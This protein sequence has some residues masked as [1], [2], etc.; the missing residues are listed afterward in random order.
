MEYV[1]TCSKG[2]PLHKVQVEKNRA[3]RDMEMEPIRSTYRTRR[4]NNPRLSDSSDSESRINPRTKSRIPLN[5]AHSI[6]RKYISKNQ[7]D[8]Q[9]R[10]AVV[11][12]FNDCIKNPHSMC[13]SDNGSVEKVSGQQNRHRSQSTDGRYHTDHNRKKPAQ[14]LFVRSPRKSQKQGPVLEVFEEALEDTNLAAIKEGIREIQDTKIPAQEQIPKDL[15]LDVIISQ[16]SSKFIRAALSICS[17][18]TKVFK[19]LRI[20]QALDRFTTR[21]SKS[22]WVSLGLFLVF[23]LAWAYEFGEPVDRISE[24]VGDLFRDRSRSWWNLI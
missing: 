18:T 5:R 8:R 1:I 10:A 19:K 15:P 21:M 6:P 23:L 17:F 11:D 3:L 12:A 14:V 13:R 7:L 16:M 24:A 4:R 2:I 22:S 9:I 20:L